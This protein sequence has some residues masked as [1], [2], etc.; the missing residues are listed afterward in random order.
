MIR[1]YQWD[2]I[3]EHLKMISDLLSLKV[4]LILCHH[5]RVVKCVVDRRF[6]NVSNDVWRTSVAFQQL[7][8]HFVKFFII[9]F[10]HSLQQ[11]KI[12]Y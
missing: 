11:K 7:V 6:K 8:H 5:L 3:W 10:L 4:R 9:A 1:L 12:T 2:Y